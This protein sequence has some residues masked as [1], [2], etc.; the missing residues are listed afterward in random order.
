MKASY[1]V[2]ILLWLLLQCTAVFAKTTRSA[3]IEVLKSAQACAHEA[4][5]N[6]AYPKALK[7]SKKFV[8]LGKKS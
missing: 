7:C 6:E 2:I 8:S 4:F 5:A 1:F 3:L